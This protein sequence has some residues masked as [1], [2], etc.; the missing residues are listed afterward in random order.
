VKTLNLV[1]IGSHGAELDR[2]EFR[3]KNPE[4]CAREVLAVM[5][6]EKWV[7][8]VGDRIEIQEVKANG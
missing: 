8:S 1:M 7:L 5:H 4:D 6:A 2:V 3:A